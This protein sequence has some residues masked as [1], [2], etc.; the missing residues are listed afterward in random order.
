[1][2]MPEIWTTVETPT[3][4]WCGYKGELEVPMSGLVARRGGALI[5]DA[6]PEMQRPQREQIVSGT[7]PECWQEMFGMVKEA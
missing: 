3:C 2:S 5:Q 1:M 7:H 4:T 6:F